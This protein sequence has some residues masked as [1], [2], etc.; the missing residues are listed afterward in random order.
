MARPETIV[1]VGAGVAGVTAAGTLRDAGFKG[2]ILL[3]GEEHPLPY[4]RPPLSK[5]VLVHDE[6]ESLV[7]GHLPGDIAL[8]APA[9]I[10]LRPDD[11]YEAQRIEL[12]RRPTRHDAAAGRTGSS[13]TK[14]SES[15]TTR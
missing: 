12:R 14:A 11:W 15:T 5:A 1:V 2:R 10:G 8:R 4:D 13:S 9:N 3:L 6:F 7:A